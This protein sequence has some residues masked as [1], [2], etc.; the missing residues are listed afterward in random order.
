MLNIIVR[1][2]LPPLLICGLYVED[3][4]RNSTLVKE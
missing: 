2:S 1:L 3:P 4:Q